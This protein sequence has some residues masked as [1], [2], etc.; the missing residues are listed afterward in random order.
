MS[1]DW[2]AP[3]NRELFTRWFQFGT[4]S[5]IFRIHGKGERALFSDNWDAPTKAILMNYD[6]LRYRLM[7]YIYSLSWKVTNEGYTIMRSL[8]FD[9]RDDKNIQSIP[10][11][12]MFGP[13]FLVNPVTERLYSLPNS[14]SIKKARKVYLPKAANWY[15]FWT[16]KLIPGGQT[17]DAAATIETLPLYIKAGSIVPMG[18]YLQY[19]T[20]KVADPI[21][22][23]VYTG[24]DAEFV[25]YEDENDTYNYEK[26]AFSTIDLKWDDAKRILTIGKQKGSYP[27][28]PDT[29]TFQITIVGKN[30]GIGTGINPKP[31]KTMIYKGEEQSASFSK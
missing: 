24:A 13:A 23:R 9:F 15:D 28:M 31:D 7:P 2:T 26:G 20:E 16:G 29:R 27:G 19:A 21:E 17:I 3:I 22:L 12:Y 4:F 5:P 11:Q 6:N 1:P 10:D 30:K 14:K 25:L 8:A 18:P